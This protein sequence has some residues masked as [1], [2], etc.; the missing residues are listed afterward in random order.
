MGMYT[1]LNLFTAVKKDSGTVEVLAYM[2]G[3][4]VSPPENYPF[5]LSDHYGIMLRCSSAYFYGPE[6]HVFRQEIDSAT[7]YWQLG[8]NCSF[9]NYGGELETFLRWLAPFVEDPEE[10][11]GFFRYEE[12]EKATFIVFKEYL[13]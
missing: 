2:V 5:N 1:Q 11:A 8:V 4:R 6:I 12:D 9:K 10:V 3:Q 7:E 13:K